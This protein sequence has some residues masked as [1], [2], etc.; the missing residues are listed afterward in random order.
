[1]LNPYIGRVAALALNSSFVTNN[2]NFIAIVSSLLSQ[3]LLPPA[4]SL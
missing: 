4:L 2:S 3:H 1:M